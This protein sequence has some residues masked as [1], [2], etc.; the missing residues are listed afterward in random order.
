V[1]VGLVERAGE[2]RVILTRRTEALAHSVAQ[3][4]LQG[5]QLRDVG[6]ALRD[7]LEGLLTQVEAHN[8]ESLTAAAYTLV[9]HLERLHGPD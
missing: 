9:A 6:A 2:T 4:R 1:L 5:T 7:E 8:S 3:Q